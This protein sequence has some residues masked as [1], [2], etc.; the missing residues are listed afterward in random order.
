MIEDA[1]FQD[2]GLPP[3]YSPTALR[4]D[5]DPFAEAVGRAQAGDPAG[6][7]LWSRRSDC[8]D[9]A[10]VLEP[11]HSREQSL[12]VC[13]VVMVAMVE[14]LGGVVPPSIAVTFGWPDRIDVNGAFA[15]GLRLALA[16]CDSTGDVPD[17]MVVAITIAVS[18]DLGDVSPGLQPD[19]T[20]LFDEGCGLIDIVDFMERFGRHFLHWINRWQEDGLAPV[21]L[22]WLARESGF[23]EATGIYFNHQRI[24]GRLVALD[25]LGGAVLDI[26]GAQRVFPLDTALHPGSWSLDDLSLA[27]HAVP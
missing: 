6:T 20:T 22:A 11:D 10:V 3:L 12:P 27:R 24:A 16:P 15:G 17:W 14:A 19:R 4:A 25:D 7:F 5:Q 21:R 9:L 23:G 2:P 8:I 1:T 26:D 13:L 18:G